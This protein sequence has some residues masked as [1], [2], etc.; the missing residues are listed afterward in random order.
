MD[1]QAFL[2]SITDDIIDEDNSQQQQQF[3]MAAG[4][5]VG[6]Y[7][8]PREQGKWDGVV[9][10]F[11]LDAAPNVIEYI[12]I[13]HS[14]LKEDG[15]FINFG[16]LLYHWSGPAMRPDDLTHADYMKRFQHLDQRYMTS[17]DISWADFREILMNC[18]FEILEEKV[19][20]RSLYTADRK[21]MMNMAYRC[22]NFVA[23]KVT[24]K[25]APDSA[26]AAQNS[27]AAAAAAGG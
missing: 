18:G 14:M 4:D 26:A 17:V 24:R 11:F 27:D 21:S 6:I 10:C 13:I 22:I 23:K 1:P 19:G 9:S 12:Q 8:H 5:F 15:I 20:I 3:S 7:R 25:A 16:P 2:T